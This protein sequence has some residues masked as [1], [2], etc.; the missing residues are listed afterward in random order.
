[1]AE[2][3]FDITE[4]FECSNCGKVICYIVPSQDGGAMLRNIQE[5]L[6]P[7]CYFGRED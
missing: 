6:C 4:K 3:K 2:Y 1:M 7:S 5:I